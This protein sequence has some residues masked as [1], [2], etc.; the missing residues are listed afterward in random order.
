MKDIC[1]RFKLKRKP[2]Y[3]SASNEEELFRHAFEGNIP[4]ILKGPTGCGKTRFVEHM[5]YTLDLPLITVSCHED[6]TAG[7]LVGRYIFKGNETVWEDGPMTL[8]V[9]HGGI[10]YL[11]E[12]VEARNDTTVIIHSLTDDRRLLYIDKT[13]E[14]LRAHRDFMMVMSYNPGYQNV[15]KELKHSTR[16]R[17]MSLV[18]D[19]PGVGIEQRIIS[20]ETGLDDEM[21]LKLA[22]MGEK[23]R[24]LKGFGLTEG[25]SSRLLVYAGRL[26]KSGISPSEACRV[27]AAQSLT[28]DVHMVESILDIVR[29]FWVD[30]ECASGVK[31]E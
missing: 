2:N 29:L 14:V 27:A 3:I 31:P 24:N 13:R 16:Q 17:F 11:D 25:V 23:I 28:D 19:H 5:A 10:C 18:F 15:M 1:S 22:R 30:G 7:D 4:V 9:R 8:A 20:S 21:S 6:L 12:I 26:I